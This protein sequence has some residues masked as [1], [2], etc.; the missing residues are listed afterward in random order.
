MW[1]KVIKELKTCWE[2]GMYQIKEESFMSFIFYQLPV[3]EKGKKLQ[4]F[5]SKQ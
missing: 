3:R 2:L 5:S 4:S 1:H